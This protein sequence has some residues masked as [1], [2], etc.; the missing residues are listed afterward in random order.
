M[1]APREEIPI[2]AD[3]VE[4]RG[5]KKQCDGDIAPVCTKRADQEPKNGA[6]DRGVG[7]LKRK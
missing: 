4:E 2:S 3:I 5:E 7:I 1:S 6:T